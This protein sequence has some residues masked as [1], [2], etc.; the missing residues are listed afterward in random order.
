MYET[1]VA[2]LLLLAAISKLSNFFVDTAMY[3]EKRER[4]QHFCS[5]IMYFYV[6]R[7]QRNTSEIEAKERY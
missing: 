5:Q 7:T 6:L 1:F 3:E 4:Q 2:V